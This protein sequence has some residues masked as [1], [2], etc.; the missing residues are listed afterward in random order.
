MID[1]MVDGYVIIVISITVWKGIDFK[2]NL[3]FL[4]YGL[5]K[6]KVNGT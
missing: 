5:F 2:G 6:T 4:I 1:I 3:W